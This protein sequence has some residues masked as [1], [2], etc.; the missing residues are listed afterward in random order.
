MT[1]LLDLSVTP[2]LGGPRECGPGQQA[3]HIYA[4]CG[5]SPDGTPIEHFLLDY[6]VPVNPKQLGLST[7][8][9]TLIERQG[10]WHVVDI[11][12]REHYPCAADFIEEARVL[13]VSR[14][15][16]RT[17]D[18][19]KLGPRSTLILI[20]PEG[21]VK[22][23]AGLALHTNPTRCPCGKDHT[24]EQPCAGW[25][26]H[27]APANLS[28]LPRRKLK[29]TTYTVH[30]IHTGAPEIKFSAA[31]IM[32]VPI[33]NLT[34][35]RNKTGTVNQQSRDLAGKSSLPITLADE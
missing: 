19:S 15:I 8:G 20:H 18:F 22:N 34:V 12:G 21:Y 14:K 24:P 23:T 33:S 1:T 5:F 17:T 10:I 11:I 9:V 3:G 13:G 32:Q 16:P 27:V 30:P 28:G 35:I 7:Q 4:E 31:Y 29:R 25:H 6:P 2:A 26:W